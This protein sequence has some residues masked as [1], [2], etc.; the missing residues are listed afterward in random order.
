MAITPDT[1][2]LFL[3][4][5]LQLTVA[6]APGF[7]TWSSSDSTV[8]SV[9]HG[10]LTALSRG[11][12]TIS[13]LS[14]SSTASASVDVTLPPTI[15]LATT[16]VTFEAPTGAAA[17]P[18]QNVG[19]ANGGDGPLTNLSV[20]LITY[21][22][23]AAGWLTATLP[24]SATAPTT[25]T[26]QP[27]TAKLAAGT[28]SATVPVLSPEATNSPR[29]LTVTYV[30]DPP[31]IIVLSR[32]SVAIAAQANGALPSVQ[33]V[34]IT[35]NGGG[36]VQGLAPGTITYSAG[37]TGWLTATL[38]STVAPSTLSLTATT[39]AL[40]V[41]T[42]TA[43]V[44]LTSTT[45][46]VSPLSLTVTY[47]VTSTAAPAAI[48]LSSST[49]SFTANTG[50]ALPA[51][52]PVSVSNS[53]GGALTGL[54]A[55]ITYG[56][57]ASGWLGATLNSTSAPATLSVRPSTV[58]AAGTYTATVSVA[59]ATASN[60]PQNVGV[61]YTVTTAPIITVSAT[62]ASFLSQ[63][64]NVDPANQIINVSNT[65]G[66]SLTGL[67]TAIV[68]KGANTGWLTATV[69]GT[70][71]LNPSTTPLTLQ[72]TTGTIVPSTDTA[73]VTLSSTVSGVAPK[74][75]TVVFLR[76]AT[77]TNDVIPQVFAG[78]GGCTS[79]HSGS[80]PADGL[81]L[82]TPSSAF[83]GLVGATPTATVSPPIQ[84]RVAA[85]DSTNSW[86]NLELKG[87]AGSANMPF[88]CS[89]AGTPPCISSALQK[90]VATWIQQGAIQ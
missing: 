36:S 10:M 68:Y 79:C 80:T 84:F 89:T 30:I 81:D 85:G 26:V 47:S 6:S 31:S 76:Q 63:Q 66:G 39:T 90:L 88:G 15:A 70:A 11:H 5:S 77:L 7:I 22:P 74:A 40:A 86:L 29:S 51:A 35:N 1:A 69:A 53:G 24:S 17:P 9:L 83:A 57:G 54:T 65:G 33:T 61:T 42:Y 23:G 27:T 20:G 41:G 2:A 37:A 72:V 43:T 44:P 62:S 52:Q 50:G 67:S 21:S 14:G 19:V 13:A 12:A 55:S 78:A 48:A 28:Y 64:A 87:Q 32:S 58:L 8:V 49:A 34:S 56:A 16:G 60:T 46:G 4:D 25:L 45:A 71:P 3:G 82:S 59:S 75:V 18:A 73:T 38:T